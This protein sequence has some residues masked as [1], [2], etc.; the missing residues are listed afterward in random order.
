VPNQA[1]DLQVQGWFLVNI[2]FNSLQIKRGSCEVLGPPKAFDKMT[3]HFMNLKTYVM[4][5][6]ITKSD[7][8]ALRFL[9]DYFSFG[10]NQSESKKA[11]R[12]LHNPYGADVSSGLKSEPKGMVLAGLDAKKNFQQKVKFSESLQFLAVKV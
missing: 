1:R 4:M 12:L 3:L 10:K 7:N 5:S 6:S 9:V 11:E 8:E 2:N